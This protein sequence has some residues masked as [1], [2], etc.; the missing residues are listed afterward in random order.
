MF[1]AKDIH[2]ILI[3][4]KDIIS[5]ARQQDMEKELEQK[6]HSIVENKAESKN[7]RRP[8][9]APRLTCYGSLTE[10]TQSQPGT[11]TDGFFDPN[12]TRT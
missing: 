4:F 8:Y 12:C 9:E 1:A 7:E 11:G 6:K 10:L 2:V 3:S 5:Q